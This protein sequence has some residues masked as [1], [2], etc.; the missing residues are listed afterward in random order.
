MTSTLSPGLP[1]PAREPEQQAGLPQATG[2]AVVTHPHHLAGSR[3]GMRQ[4]AR[5]DL[6][7]S[8]LLPTAQPC[9]LT[10]EASTRPG[11]SRA[12]SDWLGIFTFPVYA[13]F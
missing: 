12:Q 13:H 2:V 8:I 11:N 7:S 10:S 6:G 9:S 4:A 5:A 1:A 3:A